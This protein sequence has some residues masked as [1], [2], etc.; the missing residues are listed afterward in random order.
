MTWPP[1]LNMRKCYAYVR[2][3]NSP[4]K[5]DTHVYIVSDVF[6]KKVMDEII[7][8]VVNFKI[9]NSIFERNVR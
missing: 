8:K 4:L 7:A 1:I 9:Y 6:C 3:V 5:D 2:N